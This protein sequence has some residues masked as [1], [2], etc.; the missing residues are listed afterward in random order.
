VAGDAFHEL[1]LACSD[2]SADSDFDG[3]SHVF[4]PLH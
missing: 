4:C 1:C 3:F 2:G